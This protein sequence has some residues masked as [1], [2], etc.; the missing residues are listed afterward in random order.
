MWEI[1]HLMR[2]R[3]A[4]GSSSNPSVRSLRSTSSK[5]NIAANPG[6]L[7][8]SKCPTARKPRQRLMAS[9]ERNSSAVRSMSM[10]HVLVL[11]REKA[12]EGAVQK[13]AV[14]IARIVIDKEIHDYDTCLP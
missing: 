4:F 13:E 9:M 2:Q 11:A 1:C 6:A 3:K 14:S 8:L 5:T 12:E 10:R 7:V